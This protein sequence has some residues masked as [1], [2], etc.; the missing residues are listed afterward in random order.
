M[1][2]VLIVGILFGAGLLALVAG[3]FSRHWP[4]WTCLAALALNL[5]ILAALWYE[6]VPA[7]S[8]DRAAAG[9]E[10]VAGPAWVEFHEDWIPQFGISFYLSMDGLSL[11]LLLLTHVL[12]IAAVAASWQS[13]QDRVGFFHFNLMLLLGAIAGVFTALDLF[14]FYLFWELMLIPLYLL[15]AM[16]GYEKRV[17]AAIKFFIFTQAG[18]LLMLLGILGL[19][20]AHGRATGVYTF[21]YRAL[22]HTPLA[23]GTATWLLLAFFIALA[24]K[25]PAVPLHTWLPLAHTQA[26]TAGSVVLAGLVLKAGAYGLIRFALPLF[27]QAAADLAPAAMTI[28]VVGILYGAIVAFGQSDLKRLVAYTSIS[29]MGFVLLGVFSGNELGLQGAVVILLAHGLTTSALFIWVGVLH[30]RLHTREI[31]RMGGLWSAAPRMGGAAMVLAMASLGLPGLANFVGEFLVLLG[32]FQASAPLA[33]AATLGFVVATVYSL[34]MIQ[35]TF[36]GP[37][38]PQQDVSDLTPRE[39]AIMGAI[40]AMIVWIG[41]HPQ[42]VLDT[43]RPPIESL[44]RRIAPP[45]AS[46][47]AVTA[48][49]TGKN[50]GNG[51]GLLLSDSEEP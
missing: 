44:R 25:L 10:T 8:A 20:F 2:L 33:V 31:A 9:A 50:G 21:D 39:T 49:G 32:A 36:H 23:P 7:G 35:R 5:A 14:L 41:V 16:W 46:E 24:V 18:G 45:P 3:R 4:R 37:R 19:Y 17:V 6:N 1:E 26:P 15:I 43:S 27:P 42:T 40:I 48:L 34:A 51:A 47:A 11:L 22:L 30:E 29:H 38:E 28:G 13:V 12:G